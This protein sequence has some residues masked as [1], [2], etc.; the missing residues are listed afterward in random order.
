MTNEEKIERIKNQR[1]ELLKQVNE[2]IINNSSQLSLDANEIMMNL[3]FDEKIIKRYE[4]LLN[5]QSLIQNLTL[6]IVECNDPLKVIELRKKLNYYINKIKSEIKKRNIS[7]EKID[8]YQEESGYL[9]KDIAKYIRYLKR[10]NNIHEIEELNSKIDK[11]SSEDLKLLKRM[12][13]NE[14]NYMNKN[15]KLMNGIVKE[16]KEIVNNVETV[17]TLD[18]VD[19]IKTIKDDNNL[20]EEI[21]KTDVKER[22][23][24]DLDFKHNISKESMRV[25]VPELKYDSLSDYLENRVDMYKSTYGLLDTYE[26]GTSNMTN[27]LN[28]FKNIPIFL[29]NRKKIKHMEIDSSYFYRGS[30]LVGYI[31]YSKK[32]NSIVNGLKSLFSRTYLF[33]R[34]AQCLSDHNKCAEWIINYC[35]IDLYDNKNV[36]TI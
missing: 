16:S 33:S 12:L 25:N 10:E 35:N 28:F 3:E 29:E 18:T 34:E 20:F 13:K 23:K 21:I 7:Q 22:K 19:N 32:K 17:E 1:K 27:V 14:C 8:K 36:K 30:D 26:Y 31:E 11:L 24:L 4:S 15:T 2:S 9:R 5:A 6:E